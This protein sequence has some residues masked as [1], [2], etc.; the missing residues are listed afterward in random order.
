[1]SSFSTL[2]AFVTVALA[3]G[4]FASVGPVADIPIV[5]ANLSPD[6]FT[7]TTVLA[8]G[9]FPGPLIVGNKVG[10]YDRYFL[11]EKF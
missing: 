10:L 1:M 6:G 11:Q 7:R 3:L 9:T 8:G 4:A 5:N 2:S